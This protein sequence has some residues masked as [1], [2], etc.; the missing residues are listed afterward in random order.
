M[1]DSHPHVQDGSIYHVFSLNS[2]KMA[3]LNGPIWSHVKLC[4]SST[5]HDIVDLLTKFDHLRAGIGIK[6][7][8]RLNFARAHLASLSVHHLNNAILC[9]P[10]LLM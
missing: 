7:F 6:Q 1:G 5:D 2:N 10:N 3:L 9:A 8:T 4:I